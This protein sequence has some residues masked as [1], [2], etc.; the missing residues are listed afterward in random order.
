MAGGMSDGS[1]CGSIV[2]RVKQPNFIVA[3]RI[4]TVSL[5]DNSMQAISIANEVEQT[6]YNN[7]TKL[8]LNL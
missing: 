4:K 7:F 1:V 5:E 3:K 6:G 8:N 2:S